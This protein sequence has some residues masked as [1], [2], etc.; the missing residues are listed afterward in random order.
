MFKYTI[1]DS[2]VGPLL[3][4]GGPEGLAEI[5]FTPEG[6]PPT[7]RADWEADPGAFTEVSAQLGEYFAG[8]RRDFTLALD[9][10]GTPFQRAVWAALETIPYGETISYADLAR[11][12][13]KPKAVRAV[14]AANGQ[15][16]LPIVIPCHRVIGSD[17]SLTGYGG[18]LPIKRALLDLE[19]QTTGQVQG[20]GVLL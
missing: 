18:G 13:N 12:I 14:G 10:H 8:T 4:V 7:P 2:P 15:N 19:R 5:R 6:Q 16:P 3:L 11:R 1:M 20:Q 9:P 17:G